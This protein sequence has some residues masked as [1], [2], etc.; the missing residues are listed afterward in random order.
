AAAEAL[1]TAL[2]RGCR[3]RGVEDGDRPWIASAVALN[4]A[5]IYCLSELPNGRRTANICGD[6]DGAACSPTRYVMATI[7]ARLRGDVEPAACRPVDMRA[8]ECGP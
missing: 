8:V 3:L 5:G 6:G 1:A 7:V 2:V 4:N